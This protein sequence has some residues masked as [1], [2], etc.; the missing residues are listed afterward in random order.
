MF[1]DSAPQTPFDALTAGVQQRNTMADWMFYDVGAL[2]AAE[3]TLLSRQTNREGAILVVEPSNGDDAVR[4]QKFETFGEFRSEPGDLLRHFTI[5][6]VG[7]S[8][9]GAAAFARTLAN[10][11]DAPVGAIVSGYGMADLLGEALGGWFF[12]RTAN[13][14]L[15]LMAQFQRAL[16]VSY[17][18]RGETERGGIASQGDRTGAGAMLSPETGTLVRLLGEEERRIETLLGHSKGCL[19]ISYALQEIA[20]RSDQSHFNRARDV[21]VITTGAVVAFPDGLNR[22][23]QYLGSL[24]W[25]GGMN[26]RL[27]L[28]Y[29]R[30]PDAWHHLNPG[31]PFHM[32]LKRVLSGDYETG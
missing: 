15:E 10:H 25:F 6:G 29:R 2:S 4:I 9:V 27:G 24:D 8:D 23:N 13:Q 30:V 5:A 26:S 1:S 18:D 31:I 14:A 32:D 11:L 20:S 17:V 12:F 22:L 19:S 7:S 28:D 3:F 21:H 16:S